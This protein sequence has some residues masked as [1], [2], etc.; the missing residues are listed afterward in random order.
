MERLDRIFVDK[1]WHQLF[2]YLR[3][4]IMPIMR[5]DHCPMLIGTA[6]DT[7]RGPHKRKL[8]FESHW[9]KDDVTRQIIQRIWNINDLSTSQS[10]DDL[11]A[12]L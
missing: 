9:A 6:Y 1:Q 12:K 8:I 10:M 5:S 11:S 2:S 7:R 3:L 4:E